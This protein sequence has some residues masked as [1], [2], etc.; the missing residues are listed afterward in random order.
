MTFRFEAQWRDA[1]LDA[2]IPTPG[3][4][5]PPMT[6]VDRRAFWPRF[7]QTAP[8]VLQAGVR[9]ATLV[10]GGIV[11]FVLGY[12][13]VFARLDPAQR[14]EVLQRATRLPGGADLLLALKLIACFAYFDDAE[15]QRVARA[16]QA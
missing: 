5:L 3:D 10:I 15:V 14:E 2:M 13:R 11:P 9:L 12:R 16:P 7:E 1:L 8:W 4:G 6:E